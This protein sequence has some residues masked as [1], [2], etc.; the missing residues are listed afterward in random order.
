M[1]L[2][3]G[4]EAD[5]ASGTVVVSPNSTTIQNGQAISFSASGG[6]EYQWSLNQESYGTLSTRSGATTT[7]TSRISPGAGTNLTQIIRVTSIVSGATT[8]NNTQVT[9]GTAEAYVTHVN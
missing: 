2:L 9:S 3:G 1:L 7:Y 4:C 5:P 8:T 6:F